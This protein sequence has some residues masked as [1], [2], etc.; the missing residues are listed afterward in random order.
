[1]NLNE[2]IRMAGDPATIV[3][4][5]GNVSTHIYFEAIGTSVAGRRRLEPD[6][7]HEAGYLF[8]TDSGVVSGDLVLLNDI[9]YLVMSLTE[10][11]VHG[12]FVA[13]RGMLFRCNSEI[14]VYYF[15]PA[16]SKA[17]TLHKSGVRCLIT[18]SFVK[19]WPDD[20]EMVFDRYRSSSEPFWLYTQEGAGIK[21]EGCVIVDQDGRRFRV[22]KEG[23]PFITEGILQSQVFWET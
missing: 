20:T 16:T 21:K 23:D 3:R 4:D 14:S 22:G 10:K 1:M 17:D 8:P 12:F 5:A 6:R 11:R 9:Y 19:E 13:Y 18:Q 2:H 15:N 7:Q